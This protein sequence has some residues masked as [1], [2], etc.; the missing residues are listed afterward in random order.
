MSA[1]RLSVSDVASSAGSPG[2]ARRA[3][4]FEITSVLVA[5]ARLAAA[6]YRDLRG[7]IMTTELVAVPADWDVEQIRTRV[8]KR[9]PEGDW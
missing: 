9:H 5:G 7:A 1:G 4:R 8:V 2:D 3:D 6:L